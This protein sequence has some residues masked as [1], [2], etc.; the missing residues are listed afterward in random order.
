[1]INTFWISYFG[2]VC[3]GARTT[4]LILSVFFSLFSLS[5]SLFL[6]VYNAREV[7]RIEMVQKQIHCELTTT[8]VRREKELEV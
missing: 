6:G 7:K 8:R 4:S 1:M 5:L 2:V 3:F